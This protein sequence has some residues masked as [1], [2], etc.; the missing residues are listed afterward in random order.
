LFNDISSQLALS[1]IS[2]AYFC[3]TRSTRTLVCNPFLLYIDDN[4]HFFESDSRHKI[5]SFTSPYFQYLLDFF[6]VEI[7]ECLIMN[8]VSNF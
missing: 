6:L 3:L 2:I 1:F 5:E 4:E 7:I 8:F